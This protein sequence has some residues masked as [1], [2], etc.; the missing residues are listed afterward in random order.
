MYR[1]HLFL[2]FILGNGAYTSASGVDGGTWNQ[3]ASNLVH[4]ATSTNSVLNPNN[5][6]PQSQ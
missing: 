6:R 2:P 1:H 4:Y 5:I 3:D